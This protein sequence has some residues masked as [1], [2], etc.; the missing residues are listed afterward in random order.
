[1]T[2][3][4]LIAKLL[5]A[6]APAC[7]QTCVTVEVDNVRPGQGHLMVAAFGSADT[8]GKTPLTQVRLPAGEAKMSFQLCDLTGAV[9]ALTLYQDLNSDGK[10]GR[11]LLG[12]P[13]EPWGSSGNPGPFG[14]SWEHSQVPLDGRAITVRMTS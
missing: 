4:A 11:N 6:A 1:M 14:P 13:T 12:I 8:F 2:R 7:A 9:V 10:M 5:L 3:A